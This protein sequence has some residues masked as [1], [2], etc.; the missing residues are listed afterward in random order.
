MSK[1]TLPVQIGKKYV[2]R[3]GRVATVTGPNPNRLGTFLTDT[4]FNSDKTILAYIYPM[5]TAFR[6][7]FDVT[8]GADFVEDYAGPDQ[9]LT[10]P[11]Q[12]GKKYV[13]RRGDTVTIEAAWYTDIV[14][15][16][17]YHNGNIIHRNLFV[18]NGKQNMGLSTTEYDLVSDYIEPVQEVPPLSIYDQLMEIMITIEGAG[19]NVKAI[20]NITLKDF[21]ELCT[22]NGIKI[23]TQCSN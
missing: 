2:R 16:H 1:L 7:N 19:C 4:P 14:H 8:N 10:L 20:D 5:G 18:I 9:V 23:S 21:V 3:D 15:Y 12:I 22:K 11:I 13:N 17:E 6:T